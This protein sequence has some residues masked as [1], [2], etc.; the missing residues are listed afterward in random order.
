MTAKEYLSQ[1]FVIRKMV[2]AKHARIKD[3]R[4]LQ[5]CLSEILA[6]MDGQTSKLSSGMGGLQRAIIGTVEELAGEVK[7]LLDV[8]REIAAVIC[9]IRNDDCKTIFYERY[10]NLKRWEAI[11]KEAGYSLRH[12]YKLRRRGLAEVNKLLRREPMPP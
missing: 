6:G 1:A 10:V 4:D 11:A 7:C 3:L 9:K 8:Q 12:V 2:N 5:N